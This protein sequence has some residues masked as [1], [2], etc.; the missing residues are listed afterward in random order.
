MIKRSEHPKKLTGQRNQCPS[1]LEHF[2]TNRG[3]DAHRTGSHTNR[4]RLC[5]TVADIEAKGMKRN[6]KGFWI[7]PMPEK[8]VERMA[9]IRQRSNTAPA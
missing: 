6:E 8:D 7:M 9:K 5:L 4:Q 2:N 1:C 3:F